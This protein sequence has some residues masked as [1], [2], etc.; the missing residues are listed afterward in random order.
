MDSGFFIDVEQVAEGIRRVASE[1]VTEE[2]LR[3]GV[4]YIL[5]SEVIEKLRRAEGVEI[6]Y[7]S[8]RP[9]RAR[10][11]VTLVS[12]A[13]AD[14]LYGHLIIEYE[15]PRSFET[16]GGF[17]RAVEQ[18]KGYIVDHA[19]VEARFPRYFGVVL[20]GYKIGLLGIER[21][22]RGLRVGV[23]L[24]LTEALWLSWLRRLLGLG[25]GRW[26]LRSF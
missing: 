23:R 15:R 16:R 11:E 6:P 17:E 12:G 20:D 7:S 25:G 1:A 26:V 9:P 19:E 13:R 5:W 18:V 8:W 2:D 21:L 22:L 10:Y 3:V 14:A 4:E 24:M